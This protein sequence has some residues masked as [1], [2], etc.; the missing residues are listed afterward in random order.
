M[1]RKLEES[2]TLV[3]SPLNYLLFVIFIIFFLSVLFEIISISIFFKISQI[4]PFV[5]YYTYKLSEANF[6]GPYR[7]LLI[8]DYIGLRCSNESKFF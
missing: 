3:F 6:C 2:T 8:V 4:L 5:L 7:E 1:T